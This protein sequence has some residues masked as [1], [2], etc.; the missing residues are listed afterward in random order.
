M[1]SAKGSQ[2]RRP[3]VLVVDDEADIVEYL[4]VALEDSGYRARGETDPERALRI[5]REDPPDVLLLDIMM[6]GHTGMELY[7]RIRRTQEGAGLPI[8]FISGYSRAEDFSK[9]GLPAL[10]KEN[11]APPAG[12]LEKPLSLQELLEKIGALV[13]RLPEQSHV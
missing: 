2:S 10:E 7:R 13:A 1:S 4:T 6:P 9:T 5:L 3:L 8:L 11:L 12:Y